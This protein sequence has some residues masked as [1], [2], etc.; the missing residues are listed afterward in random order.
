MR[1]LLLSCAGGAV[2][3]GL[4]FLVYQGFAGPEIVRGVT[5]FPFATLTVNVVGGL[6]M[7]FTVVAIGERF[8]AAP[9]LRAFLMA[10]VLVKECPQGRRTH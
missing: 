2:G 5:V 7:G 4:R 9:E 8:G 10:G 6:L 3:A 1:L